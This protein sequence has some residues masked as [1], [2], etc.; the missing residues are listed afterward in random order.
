MKKTTRKTIKRGDIYYINGGRT[1]G[2]EQHTDRPAVIVSNDAN[3]YYGGTVTIAYM[4]THEKK[5]LPTHCVIWSTG[6]ESTVLCE[7]I[8]TVDMSRVGKRIGTCTREEMKKIDRCLLAS[9]QLADAEGDVEKLL[10]G[11]KRQRDTIKAYE[12]EIRKMKEFIR[13]EQEKRKGWKQN[14]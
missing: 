3:N 11:I 10:K 13:R 9:L 4:T 8:N 7:Q 12:E 5:D 6:R 2:R 1:T 14:E